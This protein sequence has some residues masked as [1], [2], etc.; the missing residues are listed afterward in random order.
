[1]PC[2]FT[3]SLESSLRKVV[4]LVQMIDRNTVTLAAGTQT[5][6][7]GEGKQTCPE[8][9]NLSDLIGA[10]RKRPPPNESHVLPQQFRRRRRR[11][12]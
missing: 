6:R 4:F 9:L 3:G 1:M 7:I 11:P 2:E 12:P 8:I 5:S 10:N